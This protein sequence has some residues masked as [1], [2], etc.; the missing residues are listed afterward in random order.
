MGLALLCSVSNALTIESVWAS[1]QLDEG[2]RPSNLPTYEMA[3]ET[4]SENPETAATQSAIMFV[5][6]LISQVLLFMGAVAVI[7]L[8]I[9]GM[10]YIFAFG[11]DERINKAKNGVFYTLFGLIIILLSYAITQ[12]ILQIVLRVDESVN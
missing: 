9:A 8:T 11:K 6:N 5:G 12:G 2:I 7:F 1:I 4:T 3:E 10:N